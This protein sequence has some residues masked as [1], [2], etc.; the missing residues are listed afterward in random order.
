MPDLGKYAVVVGGAYLATLVVLAAIIGL[1]LWQARRA[2]RALN[3]LES[4]RATGDD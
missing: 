3:A 4:E 2:A 1:S